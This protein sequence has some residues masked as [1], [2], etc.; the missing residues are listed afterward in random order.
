MGLVCAAT[1]A[2]AEDHILNDP[3]RVDLVVVGWKSVGSWKASS[4]LDRGS[5]SS[6]DREEV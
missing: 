6:D 4:T 5:R 3:T 2:A 1:V